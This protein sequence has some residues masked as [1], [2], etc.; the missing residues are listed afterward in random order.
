MWTRGPY[1]VVMESPFAG[2]PVDLSLPDVLWHGDFR[3]VEEIPPPVRHAAGYELFAERVRADGADPAALAADA[4]LL[5]A[6]LQQ[7]HDDLRASGDA[8]LDSAGVFLGNT[9]IARV[10]DARWQAIAPGRPEVG[11]THG[12]GVEVFAMARLIVESDDGRLPEF[13]DFLRQWDDHH[14]AQQARAKAEQRAEQRLVL[15][16]SPVVPAIPFRGKHDVH[17]VTLLDDLIEYLTTHY[18]AI[19]ITTTPTPH[20]PHTISPT[21]R[22]IRVTPQAPDA[23]RLIIAVDA[24]GA[25]ALRAGALHEFF[26]YG[27]NAAELEDT[28]LAVAA[29]LYR[30]TY[31]ITPDDIGG[32]RLGSIHDPNHFQAGGSDDLRDPQRLAAVATELDALPHGWA[33]WSLRLHPDN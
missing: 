25:I 28:L 3:R 10:R 15:P 19:A 13:D 4:R 8:L 20:D 11:Q 12:G 6:Y 16:D 24:V 27:P 33:P 9:L 7:R 21:V 18:R 22:T 26:F 32:Y 23:A 29:G 5:A 17:L 2:R 14:S 30:E 31:P 1:R